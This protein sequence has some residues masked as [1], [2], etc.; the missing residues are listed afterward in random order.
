MSIKVNRSKF[1]AVLESVTPGVTPREVLEQSSCFCLRNGEVQTFDEYTACRAPTNL[2][3]D[4]TGAVQAKSF[5]A[6]LQKLPD[7]DLE[8]IP[9]EQHLEVRGN[10]RKVKLRMEPEI[11]LPVDGIDPPGK[12]SKLHPDFGEAV[13]L[14]QGCCGRDE[15]QLA[16]VCVHVYPNH[17]EAY[18]GIQFARYEIKTGFASPFLM[19]K[20]S[21]KHVAAL[22]LTDFSETDCW[23]HFKGP[24]GPVLS[25]R[26]FLFEEEVDTEPYLQV[27]DAKPLT[28][29][30]N[31]E[32]SIEIAQIFSSENGDVDLVSVEV[33]NN[34]LRLSAVGISGEYGEV[35]NCKYSGPSLH[36]LIAPKILQELLARETRFEVGTGRIK[37]RGGGGKW[38]WLACLRKPER[39]G[40]K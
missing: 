11:H 40:D 36:F 25:C 9:G 26:R 4:F 1:L 10:H 34:K 8:L 29:P 20:D 31:L 18:D 5:L 33:K 28:V 15:S 2:P 12:W 35:K 22:D 39:N 37:V 13:G 6:V 19:R 38:S 32:A 21:I 16:Q 24:S 27:P 3:K 7:E 30:K 23:V 17:V 14:V